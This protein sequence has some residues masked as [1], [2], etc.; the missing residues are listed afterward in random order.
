MLMTTQM[1]SASIPVSYRLLIAVCMLLT[2]IWTSINDDI[3]PRGLSV[4]ETQ[5]KLI[6]GSAKLRFLKSLL[7]QLKARG[8]RILLFSQVRILYQLMSILIDLKATSSLS[9]PLTSSKIFFM[10]R[11]SSTCDW[12]GHGPLGRKQTTYAHIV[13]ILGWKYQTGRPSKRYGYL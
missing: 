13:F 11:G 5:Y 1:P 7:P 2:A 6:D 8:H 4:Q 9:L 12:Y 3:E 10:V